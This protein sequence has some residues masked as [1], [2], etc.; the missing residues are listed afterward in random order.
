MEDQKKMLR[1]AYENRLNNYSDQN[2]LCVFFSNCHI[3]EKP[4]VLS[5]ETS[6]GSHPTESGYEQP[7]SG[8]SDKKTEEQPGEKSKE[9]EGG[10]PTDQS[11]PNTG[12]NE[13]KVSIPI[14]FPKFKLLF[15]S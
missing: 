7:S 3:S 10:Q 4:T 13:S 6:G 8:S 9:S 2:P 15:C 1:K 5:G 11:P 12:G 14:D